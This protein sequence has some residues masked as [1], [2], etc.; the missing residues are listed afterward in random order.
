MK[1]LLASL[2]LLLSLPVTVLA[3]GMVV[4]PKD[5]YIQE[6]AQKAA[7]F[8]TSGKEDLYLSTSFK[9]DAKEFGWIVPTPTKPE[10]KKAPKNIFTK[11]AEYTVPK[12]NFYEK[13]IDF[14]FHRSDYSYSG[15]PEMD[16]SVGAPLS[17]VEKSAPKV[18]VYEE[19]QV[20]AFDSAVLKAETAKDLT[21][22]AEENNF[23]LPKEGKEVIDEYTQKGWFFTV[24][25]VSN[26]YQTS[27]TTSDL[28]TGAI[29]PI[30]LTFETAE[31]VYPLKI[32]GTGAVDLTGFKESAGSQIL[33]DLRGNYAY[34]RSWFGTKFKTPSFS[35]SKYSE[36]LKF[37][38]DQI[39][40]YLEKEDKTTEKIDAFL[41]SI[42]QE[43]LQA[44]AKNY[45][46]GE[47]KDYQG[48]DL[49]VFSDKKME[50]A[51]YKTSISYAENLS[52][53]KI[54]LILKGDDWEEVKNGFYLTKLTT[55]LSSTEMNKDMFFT[56]YGNNKEVGSGSMSVWL[57]LVTIAILPLLVLYFPITFFVRSAPLVSLFIGFIFFCL[58]VYLTVRQFKN[59]LKHPLFATFFQVYVIMPVFFILLTLIS[60]FTLNS[61]GFY[62][63]REE[64]IIILIAFISLGLAIVASYI[65]K[66][67]VAK[68]HLWMVSKEINPDKL[69][70]LEAVIETQKG[71]I[72]KLSKKVDSIK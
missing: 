56:N 32:S 21:Q 41:G 66:K 22:W 52:A 9:G 46:Y 16:A 24:M 2:I 62:P 11:L 72:E 70:E 13:V 10:I 65:I 28:K 55:N 33:M 8:Y 42:S 44:A 71:E 6:A 12:D 19:K 43:E 40:S 34:S 38:N 7:I 58:A 30:H 31:M 59:T 51:N 4:F 45:G 48:I 14:F 15:L 17:A 50:G 35:Q 49:Y 23:I 63:D 20:G 26:D 57:W 3:D 27:K 36:L 64:L 18:T 54:N 39:G 61:M 25:K 67:S 1:K 69:K 37:Y 68:F 53:R 60:A 5:L 47:K 29:T